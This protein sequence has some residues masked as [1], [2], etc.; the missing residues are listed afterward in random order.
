MG[1]IKKGIT[2]ISDLKKGSTNI[3]FVYK[4]TNLVWQRAAPPTTL[5]YVV[6]GYEYSVNKQ[7]PQNSYV[8]DGVNIIFK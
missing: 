6:N 3:N 4:G 7:T 1:D 2:S 8:V 5:G